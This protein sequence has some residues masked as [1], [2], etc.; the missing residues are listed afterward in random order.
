MSTSTTD[1]RSVNPAMLAYVP[2]HPCNQRVH[3]EHVG[4]AVDQRL[5]DRR[6]DET[7]PADH[8]R[9]PTPEALG[10]RAG[11][12]RPFASS[13]R[14]SDGSSNWKVPRPFIAALKTLPRAMRPRRT[15]TW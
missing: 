10:D 3:D 11:R 14:S 4:A 5:R 7:E 15:A 8:E 1:R 9:A 12:H 6:A 13:G 2:P